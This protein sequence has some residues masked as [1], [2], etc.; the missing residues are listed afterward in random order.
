MWWFFALYEIQHSLLG[1][2]WLCNSTTYIMIHLFVITFF[3][4]LFGQNNLVLVTGGP[5]PV[6]SG[7]EGCLDIKGPWGPCTYIGKESILVF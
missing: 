5:E 2:P 1:E 6:G 4:H 7:M 3:F